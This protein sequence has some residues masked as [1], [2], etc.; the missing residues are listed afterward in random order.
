MK[1]RQMTLTDNPVSNGPLTDELYTPKEVC[2]IFKITK[3]TLFAWVVNGRFPPPRKVYS[4][5]DNRWTGTELNK[6]LAMMP[7][8]TAYKD[9]GYQEGERA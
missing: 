9:C 7:V 4:A 2:D 6:V 8:A 1:D 5:G 3:N